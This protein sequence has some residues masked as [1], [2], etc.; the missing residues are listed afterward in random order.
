MLLSPDAIQKVLDQFVLVT[1]DDLRPPKSF[2]MDDLTAFLAGTPDAW[3]GYAAGLPVPRNYATA[4]GRS[5]PNELLDALRELEQAEPS[6]SVESIPR[7]RATTLTLP[8]A[9]GSG[10]TTL[11][12]AAAFQA[13]GEGYPALLLRPDLTDI[14]SE[15][16]VGFATARVPIWR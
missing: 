12:R 13:A 3:A 15:V 2:T 1:E 9:G 14:D 10:A 16:L 5:L 6:R 7:R 8:C 4:G 11:L